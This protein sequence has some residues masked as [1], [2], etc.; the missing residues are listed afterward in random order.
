MFRL[1]YTH[2]VLLEIDF[3]WNSIEYNHKPPPTPLVCGICDFEK[4][5]WKKYIFCERW[6]PLNKWQIQHQLNINFNDT[7]TIC[8]FDIEHFCEACFGMTFS[9][10][11]FLF[12]WENKKFPL[13]ILSEFSDRK[14]LL[15]LITMWPLHYENY[16]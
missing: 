15:H 1:N 5:K 6:F 10:N 2:R 9:G 11:S 3:C 14:I 12:L 13:Y 8:H 7:M 16:V 4:N